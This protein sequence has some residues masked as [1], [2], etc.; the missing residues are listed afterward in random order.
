MSWE[1]RIESYRQEQQAKEQVEEARIR[2]E[3][4]HALEIMRTL[5]V[6]KHLTGIRDEV[7]K[8]GGIEVTPSKH[9]SGKY[10]KGYAEAR[11]RAW[12]PVYLERY[13]TQDRD[14]ADVA[15]GGKMRRHGTLLGVVVQPQDEDWYVGIGSHVFVAGDAFPF[16][17]SLYYWGHSQKPMPVYGAF[18]AEPTELRGF[19]LSEEASPVQ[20][21]ERLFIE[22]CIMRKNKDSAYIDLT[23][24]Y[25]EQARKYFGIL[26]A[27][28]DDYR[29]EFQ[30]LYSSWIRD[31][32]ERYGEIDLS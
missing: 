18:Q 15:G 20:R 13:L 24:P 8:V 4:S 9:S 1:G 26:K 12:W 14:G 28:L 11:L 29:E 5:E 6:E 30:E 3:Q 2:R 19:S 31:F 22:D 27:E 23:P 25:L 16:Y 10:S 32:E 17:K 7:W 21:L